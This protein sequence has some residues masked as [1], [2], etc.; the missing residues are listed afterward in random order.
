MA[1]GLSK[2]WVALLLL[3]VLSAFSCC[4]LFFVFK[5]EEY[6]LPAFAF[7][8]LNP[9]VLV[10]LGFSPL[11]FLEFFSV[12][13]FI[14]IQR[15]MK[16]LV[17]ISSIGLLLS[18]FTTIAYLFPLAFVY[19]FKK[20]FNLKSLILKALL[21][22]IGVSFTRLIHWNAL[23]WLNSNS[24]SESFYASIELLRNLVGYSWLGLASFVGLVFASNSRIVKV[25]IIALLLSLISINLSLGVAL[26]EPRYILFI[27]PWTLLAF[28]E[29][30][31]KNIWVSAIFLAAV[32]Y[33]SAWFAKTQKSGFEELNNRIIGEQRREF[34]TILNPGFDYMTGANR[35]SIEKPCCGRCL[36]TWRSIQASFEKSVDEVLTKQKLEVITHL[37]LGESS[38]DPIEYLLVNGS[39]CK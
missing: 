3:F 27:A 33:H 19:G 24:K 17:I 12:L 13:S 11:V 20:K 5:S 9:A 22:L 18:S 15:G 7:W 34:R 23:D 30:K 28:F 1:I 36:F 10:I 32:L 6:F 35:V 2:Y 8:A 37:H 39:V 25:G 16:S 29:M 26:K 38:L 14:G 4:I 21:I 31:P